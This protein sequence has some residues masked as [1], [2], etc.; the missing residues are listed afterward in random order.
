MTAEEYSILNAALLSSNAIVGMRG[1]QMT[2]EYLL[3]VR[4][5]SD[6]GRIED[7]RGRSLIFFHNARASLAPIWFET[8]LLKSGLG[9]TSQFCGRVTQAVKLTQAVLPVFFRQADACLVTRQGFET[10]VELN[11][12]IGQQLKTLEASPAM[13]PVVFVFRSDYSDPLKHQIESKIPSTV[14]GRQFLT[15]FQCDS[16]ETHPVSVLDSALELLATH[17]RLIDAANHAALAHAGI[18]ISN[19]KTGGP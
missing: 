18:P 4:R 9:Q 15:L 1:G 12:Q 6:I 13:L 10:M 8:L 5:D 14:A 11:P 2:E 17:A 19:G 7:L 3:L 16:M